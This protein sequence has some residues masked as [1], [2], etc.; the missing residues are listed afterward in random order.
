MS[1][2]PGNNN[3]LRILQQEVEELSRSRKKSGLSGDRHLAQDISGERDQG[4]TYSGSEDYH[5]FT[6]SLSELTQHIHELAVDV[7]EA[8]K[9][10]PALAILG[11]FT[12]GIIVGQLLTRR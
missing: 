6:Q 2:L 9:D 3:E 11:A 1:Q 12:L 10:H 8:A 4:E 5:E 7:E